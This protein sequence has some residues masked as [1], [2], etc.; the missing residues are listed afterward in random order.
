LHEG[1]WASIFRELSVAL[2]VGGV[3][4]GAYEYLMR[5]DFTDPEKETTVVLL[6]PDSLLMPVMAHKLGMDVTSL[7]MK[8]A[9]TVRLL[10]SARKP[11]SKLKILGHNLIS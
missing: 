1:F 6:N 3:W 10:N 11:N 9:E 4:A 8:I 2:L 7:R 5:R